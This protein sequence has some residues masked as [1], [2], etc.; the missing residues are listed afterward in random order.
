[1][2]ILAQK[3]GAEGVDS[4]DLRQID[5][6]QLS[7]QMAVVRVQTELLAEPVDQLAAQLSRRRLGE[8]DRQKVVEVPLFYLHAP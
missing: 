6:A 7:L 5:P 3:P 1:M 2:R 8:G 4:R